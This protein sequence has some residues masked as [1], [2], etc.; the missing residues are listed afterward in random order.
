M[1][2]GVGLPTT[3]RGVDGATLLEWARRADVRGLSSLGVLDRLVAGNHEPVVTL[4]AAAA[5]TR[6]IR[7][8]TTILIAAY[9]GGAAVLAKQL[10]TV[11]ELS[12]GRLAVGVAAGGRADDFEAAGQP[13]RRR[14]RRLDA[15]ITELRE[16]WAPGSG[17]GPEPAA[18]GPPIWVGGHTDAALRRAARLGQ[19]WIAGGSS[20]VPYAELAARAR[21]AWSAEGRTDRPRMVALAYFSFGADGAERAVAHMRRYYEQAGPY[22]DRAAAQTVTTESELQRTIKEHESAGCDELVFFP[23]SGDPD[24]VDLLA[25]AART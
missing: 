2:V 16:A 20:S 13:Y 4:A 3:V 22:A 19:G 25:R 11:D 6:R 10:A 21:A 9:R 17:I 7:L 5:V 1:D 18:G 24:Q 8:A 12:G 15:L 14:G 23:C